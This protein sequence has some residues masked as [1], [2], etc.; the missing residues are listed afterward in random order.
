MAPCSSWYPKR[1]HREIGVDDGID[2]AWPGASVGSTGRR[3]GH[4][5]SSRTGG[6]SNW[7]SGYFAALGILA[8]N[9][10]FDRGETPLGGTPPGFPRPIDFRRGSEH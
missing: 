8:L 7:G 2:R 3:I 5:Q 4:H 1:F 6:L 9:R 10:F